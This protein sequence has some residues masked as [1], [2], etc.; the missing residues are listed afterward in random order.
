MR[1]ARPGQVASVRH[2]AQSSASIPR[3]RRLTEMDERGIELGPEHQGIQQLAD[4]ADCLRLLLCLRRAFLDLEG[5]GKPV[6]GAPV[7]GEIHQCCTQGEGGLAGL[8]VVLKVNRPSN[9]Q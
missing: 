1:R 7:L 8:M 3:R 2:A 4:P 9:R 6:M 5:P